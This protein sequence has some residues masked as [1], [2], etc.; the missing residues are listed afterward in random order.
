MGSSRNVGPYEDIAVPV[1]LKL[2]GV[3]EI[4]LTLLVVAY[5]WRWP[6]AAEKPLGS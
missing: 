1:K 4:T 3:V 5:A 2:F 6:R